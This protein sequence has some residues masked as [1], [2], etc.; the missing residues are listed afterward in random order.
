MCLKHLTNATVCF[1][2]LTE[3]RGNKEKERGTRK[4]TTITENGMNAEC[5]LI[6]AMFIVPLWWDQIVGGIIREIKLQYWNY[7]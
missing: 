5:F 6:I 4:V 1:K 7:R 3:E 2:L